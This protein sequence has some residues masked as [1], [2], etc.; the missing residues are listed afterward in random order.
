MLS[1]PLSSAVFEGE[2]QQDAPIVASHDDDR[3]PFLL[4]KTH[5]LR[6]IMANRTRIPRRQG[7]SINPNLARTISAT[8]RISQPK[9]HHHRKL[10][11]LFHGLLARRLGNKHV[12]AQAVLRSSHELA[13]QPALLGMPQR[14]NSPRSLQGVRAKLVALARRSVGVDGVWSGL[15]PALGGGVGDAK[16]FVDGAKGGRGGDGVGRAGASGE[17][18]GAGITE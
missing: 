12:Q 18:R 3:V 14:L 13:V 10:P 4:R 5:Q 2:E 7:S 9:T 15:A 1:L 6:S 11:P 17:R 8:A 16:P